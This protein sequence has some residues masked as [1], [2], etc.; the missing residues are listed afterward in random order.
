MLLNRCSN[1]LLAIPPSPPTLASVGVPAPGP[2][3]GHAASEMSRF[4]AVSVSKCSSILA[5]VFPASHHN[6]LLQVMDRNSPCTKLSLAD[7]AESQR[8]GEGCGAWECVGGQLPFSPHLLVWQPR[9]PPARRPHPVQCES[10]EQTPPSGPASLA[11]L[12]ASWLGFYEEVMEGR[13]WSS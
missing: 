2:A 10:E 7:S 11:V 8:L 1:C 6:G 12:E 4:L 13:P 5:F 3:S 9:P